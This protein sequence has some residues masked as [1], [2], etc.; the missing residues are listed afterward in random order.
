MGIFR[1]IGNSLN[2]LNPYVR[3][4]A[5]LFPI[6]VRAWTYRNVPFIGGV[7]GVTWAWTYILR[8]IK[9]GISDADKQSSWYIKRV[10]KSLQEKGWSEEQI[11]EYIDRR[12]PTVIGRKEGGH[13]KEHHAHH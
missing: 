5:E 7:V 13:K 9:L 3:K 12:W 6:P 11:E 2:Q 4:F 1:Q 8:A 10:H